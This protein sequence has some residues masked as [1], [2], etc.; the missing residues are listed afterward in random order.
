MIP[1]ETIYLFPTLDAALIDLLRSLKPEDWA[2]P[3]LARRWCVKDVAAHLWDGN[4]R[5]LSM[6]RDGYFGEHPADTSF[7]GI[8]SFLNDLNASWVK[9][10]KRISPKVLIEELESSGKEYYEYLKQLDPMAPATF[11][12]AWAGEEVSKNWFHIAREYTEK[13]HHQM[14]IREAVGA[15]GLLSSELYHPVLQTFMMALPHAYQSVRAEENDVVQVSITGEGGGK[16]SIQFLQQQW[17]HC[18]LSDSPKAQIEIGGT[19]A[20]KIFTKGITPEEA[21]KEVSISGDNALAAYAL[22]MVTVM[23]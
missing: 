11:S 1:I 22:K 19:D 21:L 14:Q 8:V 20:W 7:P 13:W 15:N 9:A 23:A 2:K 6:L 16:W 12:V 10:A 18:P 5:T 4:L 3:T 17:R